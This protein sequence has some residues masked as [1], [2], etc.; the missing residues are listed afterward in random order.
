ADCRFQFGCGS[1]DVV[2]TTSFDGVQW[3]A[4]VRV[5]IDDIGSG[6]DHFL[7][8][9]GADRNSFA[10]NVG[11]TVLYYGY[12]VASCTLDTCELMAGFM[13]SSDG[14]NSWSDPTL[15][16]GPMSL[17]WLPSTISGLMVGDYFSVFY[18]DDGVPHPVFAAAT[19]PIGTFFESMHSTCAGCAAPAASGTRASAR[20]TAPVA[21][22]KWEPEQAQSESGALRIGAEAYRVNIGTVLPLSASGPA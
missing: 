7:G 22:Y 13:T 19:A 5:P 2:M 3:S 11:L 1:N 15:L 6:A 8:A 12:P 16:A 10:P 9:I 21:T 18:T 20:G 14:G 4:V 17:R